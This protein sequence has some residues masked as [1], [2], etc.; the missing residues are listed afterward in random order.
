[1]ASAG[2]PTMFGWDLLHKTIKRSLKNKSDVIVALVHWYLVK[3]GGL[4][5][6]GVGDDVISNKRKTTTNRVETIYFNYFIFDSD[7]RTKHADEVGSELLPDEWNDSE[8]SYTLRYTSANDD[9]FILLGT[10]SEGTLVVNIVV[11]SA[12]HKSSQKKKTT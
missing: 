2:T 5:C 8:N 1:M 9:V 11:S 6:L 10:V 3:N 12:V 4:L 7:Q